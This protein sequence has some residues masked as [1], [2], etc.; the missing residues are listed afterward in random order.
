MTEKEPRNLK[1]NGISVRTIQALITVITLLISAT[2]LF[3]TYRMASDYSDLKNETNQFIQL[4]ES[5]SELMNASDYLTEQV[6]LFAETGNR[7][8]MDN[9]FKEANEYKR[10]EKALEKLNEIAGEGAAYDALNAALNESVNLMNRE[11][12]S[13]RLTSDSYGINNA[14]LP[15][16]VQAIRLNSNDASLD[17]SAKEVLGRRYVFDNNYQDSKEI[18]RANMKYCL[19]ILHDELE[20][21]QNE[22]STDFE[23]ILLRQRVLIIVAISSI[24]LSIIFT[25]LYLVSPLLRAVV[26]IKADNTIPIMD[27]KS[28]ASLQGHIISC[29]KRTNRRRS[30]ITI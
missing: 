23:K 29:T 13:M 7:E 20:K 28:S 25:L 10:R 17:D 18:I 16:E 6:R 14:D 2:L 19:D 22:S 4:T 12:Y 8:Y 3:A 5:S 21:S 9:Y 27:P 15:E 1:Q 26:H 24:L 11:Y 30:N